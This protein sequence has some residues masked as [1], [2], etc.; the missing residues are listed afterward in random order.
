MLNVQAILKHFKSFWG[1]D[2]ALH[3]FNPSLWVKGISEFQDRNTA[4]S[5]LA[6]V[7]KWNFVSKTTHKRE[8]MYLQ[9]LPLLAALI[10]Y[11]WFTKIIYEHPDL[12][13]ICCLSC[14]NFIFH[15]FWDSLT[16]WP[17]LATSLFRPPDWPTTHRSACFCLLSAGIN[18]T[19]C[20]PTTEPHTKPRV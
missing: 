14:T 5:R 9:L 7:T 18:G 3:T 12:I 15:L 1:P 19:V 2:T 4:S 8:I 16:V 20:Q 17:R 6:K 10:R 11:V 13:N